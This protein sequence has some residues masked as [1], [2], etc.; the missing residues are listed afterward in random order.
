MKKIET[1]KDLIEELQKL[2]SDA[3]IYHS[4][5]MMVILKQKYAGILRQKCMKRDTRISHIFI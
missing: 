1:V 3:Y 4:A 2:P 5:I